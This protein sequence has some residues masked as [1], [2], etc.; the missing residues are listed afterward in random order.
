MG[1][2][3]VPKILVSCA[4]KIPIRPMDLTS[5]IRPKSIKSS[6]NFLSQKYY[7]TMCP[8]HRLLCWAIQCYLLRRGQLSSTVPVG[9][10]CPPRPRAVGV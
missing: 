3:S 9:T 7:G 8:P 2:I 4:Y 1:F 5:H 10:H 6:Y